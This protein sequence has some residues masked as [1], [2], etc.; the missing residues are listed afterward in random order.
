VYTS[1]SLENDDE[2][3]LEASSQ[4]IE[5][6]GSVGC[7]GFRQ[8]FPQNIIEGQYKGQNREKPYTPYTS[9]TIVNEVETSSEAS[10]EQKKRAE[11]PYTNPTNSP[12]LPEGWEEFVL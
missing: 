12:S 10:G 11:K 2:R 5:E 3:P 4:A 1:S 7:V 6:E 9:S 8:V